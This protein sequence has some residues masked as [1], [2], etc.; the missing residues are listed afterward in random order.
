MNR[1]CNSYCKLN[2]F[3]INNQMKISCFNE[4]IKSK[5]KK[6]LCLKSII[7]P[8]YIVGKRVWKLIMKR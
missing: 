7:I 3:M 5:K 2:V 4:I 1:D 6:P 8:A